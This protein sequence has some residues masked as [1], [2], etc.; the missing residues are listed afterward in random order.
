MAAFTIRALT[1]HTGAEVLGLDFTKPIDAE[2]QTTLLAAFAKHHVLVM[3]DQHFTPDQFKV[4]AQ[5]YGVLQQHDKK[6]HHIPA[7]P[8]VYYVFNHEMRANGKRFTASE[9]FPTP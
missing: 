8:D 5:V 4:A 3:R 7:H 6:E 9:T 1:P 2:T